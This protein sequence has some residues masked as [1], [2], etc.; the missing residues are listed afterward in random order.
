[1]EPEQHLADV[2][3]RAANEITDKYRNGQAKHGD[4][5]WERPGILQE[6]RNE[7][8]DQVV[9]TDVLREQLTVLRRTLFTALTQINNILIEPIEPED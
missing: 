1:M 5:L 3:R 2:L 6:T 9:Y 8:L 7:A 4:D